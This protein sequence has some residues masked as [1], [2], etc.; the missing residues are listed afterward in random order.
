[1]HIDELPSESTAANFS[2][3]MSFI[4]KNMLVKQ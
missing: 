1:M 4:A 3:E 2:N